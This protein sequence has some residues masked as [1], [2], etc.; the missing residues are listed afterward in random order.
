MR[1]QLVA[2]NWKMNCSVGEAV[3]LATAVRECL[4]SVV[5]VDVAVCPS[6][7]ALQSVYEVLEDTPVSVGAQDV[8]YE[9][10]GAYTGAISPLMIEGLC[11]YAIVGHSERRKWFGEDE[12]STSRKVSALRRHGI[13]PI[14]CVG[15]SLEENLA[16][17]TREVLVRQLEG[18][19]GGSTPWNEIVVA[20]EP[21]WAIGTGKAAEADQVNDTVS[22]IRGQIGT[23]WDVDTARDIRILYGGS[24]TS[25]NVASFVGMSEIDG[26]L[27]GGASLRAD[28]FCQIVFQS[29]SMRKKGALD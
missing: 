5:G 17:K 11:R 3:Q 10:A 28:E 9:D 13:T 12:Q 21:V 23:I 25:E 8:F 29:A 16:G 14:L 18:A 15:E 2:G 20:Y 26:T 22:E 24:V 4:G 1:R 6:F 7:V 27:V 19:L